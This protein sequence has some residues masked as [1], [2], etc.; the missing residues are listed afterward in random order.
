[1]QDGIVMQIEL[2]IKTYIFRKRN[3][4]HDDDNNKGAHWA[5][6]HLFPNGKARNYYPKLFANLH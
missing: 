5:I 1:M 2:K 3:D 4:D 6:K